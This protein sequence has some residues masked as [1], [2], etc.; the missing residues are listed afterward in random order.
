MTACHRKHGPLGAVRAKCPAPTGHARRRTRSAPPCYA[1]SYA[2]PADV[3]RPAPEVL[4]AEVAAPRRRTRSPPTWHA[5]R[6]R[7]TFTRAMPPDA[8]VR[9]PRNRHWVRKEPRLALPEPLPAA[10]RAADVEQSGSRGARGRAGGQPRGGS[11]ARGFSRGR[12]SP[13]PC[14]PSFPRPATQPATPA[15]PPSHLYARNAAGYRRP[16]PAQPAFG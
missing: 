16:G 1:A 14:A 4:S 2:L 7:P 13:P 11:A 5:R 10:S 12:A 8:D 9:G 15:A 3:A 6:R